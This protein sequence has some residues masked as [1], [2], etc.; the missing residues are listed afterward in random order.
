ME[1]KSCCHVEQIRIRAGKRQGRLSGPALRILEG[2][3]RIW[4]KA[5]HTEH[6]G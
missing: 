1:L 3:N 2:M 5:R 4:V 6:W